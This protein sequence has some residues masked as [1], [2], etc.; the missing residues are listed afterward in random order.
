MS[1]KSSQLQ[2]RVSPGEKTALEALAR[3]AGQSVSAYV[4]GRALP[5]VQLRFSELL[6]AL[7][8]EAD[9]RFVLA[10]LNDLLAGLAPME[11]REAVADADLGGLSPY[12]QNYVTAMVELAAQRKGV[13][14]PA[15]TREVVPLEEPAFAA[16]LPALRLHLLRS[17]PVAFKRRNIFVDSSIGDRV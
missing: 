1:T 16:D 5:S 17:A 3:R 11:L 10:E 7:A 14:P 6:R 2:I 8:Q 13:S 9:R 15:W 12:L 4:L